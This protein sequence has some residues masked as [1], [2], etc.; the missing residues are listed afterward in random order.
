MTPE[1]QKVIEASI[2]NEA[3]RL[4]VLN[5]L[6]RS[7]QLAES[8]APSAWAVTLRPDGFRLNVGTV[9]ALGAWGEYMRVLLSASADAPQLA[10]LNVNQTAYSS[11][12]VPQ[13]VFVGTVEEHFAAR[14][15]LEPLHHAFVDAV[16]RTSK[17]V[18][19]KGTLYARHHSPELM[20][21]A[22]RATSPKKSDDKKTE[23]H[24]EMADELPPE[25]A[26]TLFEGALKTS[27]VNIFERDAAGRDRCIAHWG[28]TCSVCRF[29]FEAVYGAIGAGFIHVHHVR[30]LSEIRERYELDPVADLR[31]VCPNCHA[32]L[33]RRRPA[34]SIEEL[35][36]EHV[37][38]R[39]ES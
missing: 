30:P 4:A 33:H 15:I 24:S 36:A 13:C 32:M 11:V 25:E 14:Q 5:Q 1:A 27:I 2:P 7:T 16:A 22:G 18:P 31:P 3:R 28:A 35:K 20:E 12:A 8:V 6:V 26:S 21:Y 19:R 34:Y 17:G 9:E 39:K 29:D 37:S 10:A 38:P 23:A